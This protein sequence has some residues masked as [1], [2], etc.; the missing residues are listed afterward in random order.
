MARVTH[1]SARGSATRET[2]SVAIIQGL[3]RIVKALQDYSQH[4]RRAYGLTGPQLWALKTLLRRGALSINE[5]AAELAVHQSTISLLLNRLERQRLVERTRSRSDRRIVRVALTQRG[6]RLAARAPEPAQGQLLHALWA[7][8]PATVRGI[9]RSVARL[10]S[11]MEVRD[12]EARFFFSD[13]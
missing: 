10:V 12:V 1:R 4:V 2:Y 6:R 13:D 5:L 11:A 7:M 9:H 8:P 3:R